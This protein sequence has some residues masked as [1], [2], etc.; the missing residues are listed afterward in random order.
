LLKGGKVN[1]AISCF[2]DTIRQDDNCAEAHYNMA[3][4]MGVQGKYNEVVKQLNKALFIEP[5]NTD[6]LN[7]L[8]WLYGTVDDTS[9]MDADKAVEIAKRACELTGY[10]EAKYLDTLAAAYASAGKFEEAKA[11]AEKALNIAK[12]TGQ[13]NLAVGIQG[14]L[15]LYE[16]GQPYRQK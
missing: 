7:N 1:E 13:G 2:G 3:M 16:A 4:A 15:K 10:K 12:K 14:R 5:N 9:V 6:F 8:A 11:A